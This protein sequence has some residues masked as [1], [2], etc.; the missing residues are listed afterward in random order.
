MPVDAISPPIR[1][2]V[3]QTQGKSILPPIVAGSKVY[4]EKILERN[5]EKQMSYEEA[6][7]GIFEILRI[8]KEKRILM[9]WY[10]KNKDRWKLE[11]L[12]KK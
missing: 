2:K 11:Y 7:N 9:D 12:I 4:V 1:E 8:Q 3:I 6:R 10:M 5:K